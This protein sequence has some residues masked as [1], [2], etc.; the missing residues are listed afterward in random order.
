MP[1]WASFARREASYQNARP[2]A[3]AMTLAREF[4]FPQW[5]RSHYH[6]KFGILNSAEPRNA[7]A[8]SR[9][10]KG[11]DDHHCFGI[12]AFG[13]IT[14]DADAGIGR[15]AGSLRRRTQSRHRQPQELL[16]EGAHQ[17]A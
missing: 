5:L 2:S 16:R 17:A 14:D 1:R 6:F 11:M 7:S 9:L 13:H 10:L 3:M 4:V 12:T 8:I 15:P